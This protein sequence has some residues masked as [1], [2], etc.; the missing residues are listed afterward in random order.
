MV[1][2]LIF[3]L[4]MVEIQR[5]GLL[6]V[7]PGAGKKFKCHLGAGKK[8]KI[9]NDNFGRIEKPLIFALPNEKGVTK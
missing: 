9:I 6:Q 4:Q 1:K 7:P 2:P 8:L 5:E 3:A